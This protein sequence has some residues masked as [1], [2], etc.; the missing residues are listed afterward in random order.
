[1]EKQTT[2]SQE[3]QNTGQALAESS[4]APL[5][6]DIQ[7][8]PYNHMIRLVFNRW[9]PF[10]LHAIAVDHGTHFSRFSRQLPISQK[11]LSQ[12]LRDLQKDGLIYRIVQPETP[13]RVVY[14]LTKTG[15]SLIELLNQVYAWGW[16]DMKRKGMTIDAL[17]EMWHG[18]REPE[19]TVMEHP[20]CKKTNRTAV[21]SETQIIDES[22][23]ER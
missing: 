21:V 12:N 10:L 22:V 7:K 4:T 18:Y 11:V 15:E 1:M 6:F 5:L 8:D 3:P 16:Q 19:Q 14:Q 9:K 20:F 2:L 13:P 17:G 23:T